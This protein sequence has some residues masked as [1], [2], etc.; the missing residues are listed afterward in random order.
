MS[1]A[2][3][4]I[5]FR[6]ATA[7]IPVSPSQLQIC[8]PTGL[9]ELR[10]RRRLF[11]I[12]HINSFSCSLAGIIESEFSRILLV[13][14]GSFVVLRNGPGMGECHNIVEPNQACTPH[15]AQPGLGTI[16]GADYI[17]TGYLLDVND[18][19]RNFFVVLG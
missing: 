13:R 19:R 11:Q 6:R 15:C 7:C 9:P 8:S 2:S 1:A 17:K 4:V 18:L 5:T 12:Y 3:L 10:H 14:E 16:S